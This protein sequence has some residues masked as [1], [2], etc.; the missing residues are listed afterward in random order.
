MFL[1]DVSAS[2][3]RTRISKLLDRDD[4]SEFAEEVLTQISDY[5]D[6]PESSII[7]A[8]NKYFV[9]NM[10]RIGHHYELDKNFRL[11]TKDSIE[12]K[13]LIEI[14]NY[15]FGD[16]V[17]DYES[18]EISGKS[19]NFLV[20]LQNPKD[21]ILYV[22]KMNDKNEIEIDI[23]DQNEANEK[24]I[25][26][27]NKAISDLENQ[28]SEAKNIGTDVSELEVGVANLKQFLEN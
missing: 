9:D 11:S 13:M 28:I 18:I 10:I 17:V 8:L 1:S 7:A 27:A 12:D 3:I 19:A 23:A 14:G 21:T 15:D 2:T 16:G 22:A 24:Q 4:L 26:I 20:T 5:L 25:S 6:Q